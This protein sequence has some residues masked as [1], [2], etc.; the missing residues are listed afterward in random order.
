MRIVCDAIPFGFGPVA[1]LLALGRCLKGYSETVFVGNGCSLALAKT[2]DCFD[3]VENVDTLAPDK[4]K[5]LAECI[6]GCNGAISVMN[7]AF[8][9]WVISRGIPTVIVDSLFPMWDK[10]PRAWHLA[11]AVVLQRFDDVEQR[12]EREFGGKNVRIVGPIL[13]QL[14][15]ELSPIRSISGAL[16]VNL[17]GAEDPISEERFLCARTISQLLS[18][19]SELDSFPRKVLAVG[20][21]QRHKLLSLENEG[22]EVVTLDHT[23]FLRELAGAALFCTTPG[24]TAT[25][26]SFAL[27]VPCVFLPS[28]NYSQFLNLLAFRRN[29]AAPLGVH[30]TDYGI[31][32]DIHKGMDEGIAVRRLEHAIGHAM[33]DEGLA[34][35]VRQSISNIL[36][37]VSAPDVAASLVAAQSQYFERLGRVGTEDAANYILEVFHG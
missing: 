32:N 23:S 12:V 16:L 17:G 13:D 7:P 30:W 21:K 28:F 10:I 9:E 18:G 3:R 33:Q 4:S 31:G 27:R 25:F 8:A 14:V 5:S 29:G 15:R 11:K 34:C 2:S 19:L 6:K 22:F 1:K 37:H 26:E 20:P 36:A 24:L 35:S